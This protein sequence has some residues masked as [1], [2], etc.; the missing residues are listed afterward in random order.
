MRHW[1]SEGRSG[2]RAAGLSPATTR[3][4]ESQTCFRVWCFPV[5]I[6]FSYDLFYQEAEFHPFVSGAMG[7]EFWDSQIRYRPAQNASPYLSGLPQNASA[8]P[9][10]HTLALPDYRLRALRKE[11]IQLG[12]AWTQGRCSVFSDHGSNEASNLNRDL[13]QNVF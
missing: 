13:E 7:V 8:I 5:S 3:R 2:R 4:M 1:I 10:P 9:T 12:E 11:P 6:S